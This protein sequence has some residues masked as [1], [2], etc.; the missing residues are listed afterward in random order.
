MRSG[1]LIAPIP[2]ASY[3]FSIIPMKINRIHIQNLRI[4]RDS[5][6][7]PASGVNIIHGDNGAGKTS[8]LEA[9][10]LLGQGKSF[11]HSDSGPLIRKGEEAALVVADLQTSAGGESKLGIKRS[12]RQFVARSAGQEVSRRSELFRL[13]P[14]QLITPQSHE[15]IERGPE[16]RRRYLDFGLFHVE[17]SYHQ[18]AMSYHRAL[19][20]RNSALR[21]GD[22]R[23]ARSFNEQLVL[24]ANTVLHS[25]ASI[26]SEIEARLIEFLNG[27]EFPRGIS[28]KLLQGWKQGLSL[29]DALQQS[30][31]QDLKHGFTSAGVHRSQL[32]VL[33]E[34]APADKVLSRGQQKLLV[35]GLV[36]SLSRLMM[37]KTREPP[38][39]LID[40]LSAELDEKNSQKVLDYLQTIGMQLF[41]TTLDYSRYQVPDNT[42]VFH[43]EHGAILGASRD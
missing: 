20:Q 42:A 22:I 17:Q 24:F 9:I 26:L 7:E 36:L 27:L 3:S 43:V 30:E 28:L 31:Q 34:S 35:Y 16:L 10:Y 6:L 37:E 41:I 29:G 15:L 19:K 5:V 25:R 39:L 8:I 18:V 38:L 4:I 12:S 23:L 40:D 33:L 2:A 1:I 32:K 21:A 11:R 13:L 14:L